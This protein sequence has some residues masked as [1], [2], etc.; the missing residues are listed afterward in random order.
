MKHACVDSGPREI[1]VFEDDDDNEDEVNGKGAK[2]RRKR[3]VLSAAVAYVLSHPPKHKRTK[4]SVSAGAKAKTRTSTEEARGSEEEGEH[5]EWFG[6]G[7]RAPDPSRVVG[8]GVEPM[9]SLG[10]SGLEWEKEEENQSGKG[11]AL[12]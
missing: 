11:W 10:G 9:E 2:R 1:S 3:S 5:G 7:V 6:V 4:S 12:R 8:W